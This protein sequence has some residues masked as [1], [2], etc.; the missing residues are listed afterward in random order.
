[1][2][3]SKRM[4]SIARRISTS[5]ALRLLF[6]LLL[7]NGLIAASILGFTIYNVEKAALGSAWQADLVRD[8]QVDESLPRS[9]RIK[10]VVYQFGLPGGE[11]HSIPAGDTL[12]TLVHA[13]MLLLVAE[14]MIVVGQYQGFRRRSLYL[15]SPLTQMAKTAQALSET[16]F[17][18]QKFHSL[19]DAIENLSVHSPG[20]RL[21]TGHSELV[22]LENAVNNLISRMHDAYHQ[23]TRFVSDASHELRTPIAVIKGYAELLSRWGKDDPKVMEE[24]VAA[25]L[26]EADN[27]QHLVEQLLF[28]ARGDAGR[29]AFSPQVVDLSQL[30]HAAHEEYELI[31]SGHPFRIRAEEAVL[32]HGDEAMLK[33]ALRILSDNAIKYSPPGSM[34]TLRA[35]NSPEGM[36]CFSVQDNGPGIT[37]GDLPHIFERFYRSDPAR[38]RGG[39]GLGLSI[40]KWIAQRHEGH[41]DVVSSEGL[42]TRFTMNLPAYKGSPPAAEKEPALAGT[43]EEIA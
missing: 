4:N 5:F 42:G 20:A 14:A 39:T 36:A 41:I 40:A 24:S 3:E 17:D 29:A 18:E 8:I 21:A 10:G 15:L 31:G 16:R 12:T 30:V 34:I 2:S 19:E 7:V 9:L 1:M 43:P 35:Y 33:Q 27:M 13:Q 25:M 28:L 32:T 22:G 38:S 37:A 26:Q 6:I 11:V 23:Q